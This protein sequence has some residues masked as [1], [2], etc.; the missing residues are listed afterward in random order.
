MKNLNKIT[1][2]IIAGS[3]VLGMTSC[4]IFDK[5]A[6]EIEAVATSYMEQIIAGK[7]S[8]AAKLAVDGEDAFADLELDDEHMEVLNALVA[9]TEFEIEDAEG[10]KGD[11]GKCS[12]TITVADI[13]AAIED[14]EGS[15]AD[16]II[17]AIEDCSDTVEESFTLKFDYDDEWLIVDASDIAEFYVDAV[18]DISFSNLT[19]ENALALVEQKMD[20]IAIGDLEAMYATRRADQQDMT[21]DEFVEAMEINPLCDFI[22]T[23]FGT[24][25]YTASVTEVTDDHI[26]VHTD[27]TI[28]NA[29]EIMNLSFGDLE[30]AAHFAT[31]YVIA[32]DE[33]L[34]YTYMNEAF[35]SNISNVSETTS[36]TRDFTVVEDEDGNL[37][38]ESTE[39]SNPFDGLSIDNTSLAELNQEELLTRALEIA[40]EESLITAEEYALYLDSVSSGS[41]LGEC[42]IS[43]EEGDDFYSVGFYTNNQFSSSVS[44]Y[45][46]GDQGFYIEIRTWDY[47]DEGSQMMLTLSYEGQTSYITSYTCTDDNCDTAYFGLRDDNGLAAGTYEA[48][49][50][51]YNGEILAVITFVVA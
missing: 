35:I 48:E 42:S 49:I 30:T 50:I 25:N 27:A 18:D 38:I 39:G 40:Y 8:K 13:E 2:V 31:Y 20:A 44:A 46:E 4:S 21:Y 17:A 11:S 41:A 29:Q 24:M 51:G 37:I 15:D 34:A 36:F 19:E 16:S 43:V 12:V 33:D 7:Y 9:S 22:L 23:L 14:A 5:S 3:M 45:N 10:K 32:H 47:Y 1:S 6:E 28:T 26:I